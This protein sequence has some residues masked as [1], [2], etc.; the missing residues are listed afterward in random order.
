MFTDFRAAW[1]EFVREWKHRRAA[2]A[3]R[4]EILREPSPFDFN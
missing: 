4:A 2:R 3:R 1:R